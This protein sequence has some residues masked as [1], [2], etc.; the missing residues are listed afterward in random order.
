[1]IEQLTSREKIIADAKL[2]LELTHELKVKQADYSDSQ[3]LQ[4]SDFLSHFFL[5][6]S[7]RLADHSTLLEFQIR[8]GMV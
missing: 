3:L 8:N 2:A 6:T 7:K 5:D 1:M 4:I